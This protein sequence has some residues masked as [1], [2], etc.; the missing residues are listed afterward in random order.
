VLLKPVGDRV[1]ELI[2]Q[3]C[4]EAEVEIL[5]GH[6]SKDHVHLLVSIPPQVTISRFVQRLKGK[7]SSMSFH[8]C[9]RRTGGDTCGRE[10]TSVAAAATSPTM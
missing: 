1:R 9:G 7:R 2:R 8:T 10:G 6:V 4:R 5:K 3:V